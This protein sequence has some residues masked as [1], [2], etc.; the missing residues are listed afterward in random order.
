MTFEINDP[1]LLA[2]QGANYCKRLSFAEVAF[3]YRGDF[4]D[5]TAT[6]GSLL[7]DGRTY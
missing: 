1:L 4:E 7:H 5:A 3:D 6:L 2:A